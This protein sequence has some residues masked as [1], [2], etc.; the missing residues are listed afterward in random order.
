MPLRAS[1]L[2]AG[3]AILV[4]GATAG[5]FAR[6][7]LALPQGP[8]PDKPRATDAKPGERKILY[9]KNPMGLPDTSPVPKKDSMGMDYLPVYE[10]EEEQDGSVR[11]SPGRIQM[12]GVRT[13]AAARRELVHTVR[14]TG[15]VQFDET[16]QTIVTTRFE[17]FIEKLLVARTGDRVRRGQILAEV[18]SPELQRYSQ[19]EPRLP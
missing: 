17:A 5:Y 8:A 18:Y 1:R 14:A 6:D 3:A 12:L 9:Y 10:G 13:E 15:I 7:H 16:R 11:V 19:L 4:I 2:I